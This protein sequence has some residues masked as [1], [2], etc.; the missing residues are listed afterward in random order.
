MDDLVTSIQRIRVRNKPGRCSSLIKL[1]PNNLDL[2]ISHDTWSTYE[3]MLRVLKK[4][5]L[6]YS[7]SNS[8]M[9][10][11]YHRNFVN[12]ISFDFGF[13]CIY[14]ETIPGSK[15][16]FS[17]YPGA[18]ASF[19]DFYVTNTKLSITETSLEITNNSLWQFVT[20]QTV[21]YWVRNIVANRLSNTGADWVKW[22]SM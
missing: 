14:V 17:S 11:I 2:L 22:F 6:N 13:S 8:S 21:P 1:L 9:H 4:F 12:D 10:H 20:T 18:L 15:I 5:S 3:T 7:F 16:S 19:D